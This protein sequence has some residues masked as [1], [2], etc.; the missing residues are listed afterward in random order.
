MVCTLKG[1]HNLDTAC[2]K[3]DCKRIIYSS[4]QKKAKAE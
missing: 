4:C 2:W 1:K 3:M